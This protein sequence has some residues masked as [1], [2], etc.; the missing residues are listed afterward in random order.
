MLSSFERTLPVKFHHYLL[1]SNLAVYSGASAREAR[2]DAPYLRKI[3]KPSS[4][5]NLVMTSAYE[6]ES[7]RASE[8]AN[9]VRTDSG[10][11]GG[12]SCDKA[13]GG[14]KECSRREL[15]EKTHLYLLCRQT[16]GDVDLTL[17]IEFISS[18]T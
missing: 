18:K 16:F 4:R 8:R 11:G 15:S 14:S 1:G 7:E 9:A 10:G 17:K 3:G 5:E 6:R 2:S 13:H 12:A